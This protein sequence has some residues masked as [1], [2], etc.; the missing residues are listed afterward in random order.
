MLGPLAVESVDGAL[1]PV[2]EPKVRAVLAALLLA[3]GRMVDTDRLVDDVWSDQRP[4]DP[5]NTVQTKISQLR[6]SLDAGE[7][8]ARARV[9]HR[10]IGY[11][12]RLDSRSDLDLHRFR[13]LAA[14]AAATADPAGRAETFDAALALWRGPPLTDLAEFPFAAAAAVRLAEER[15]DALERWGRARVELGEHAAV[16]TALEPEAADHPLR[17]GLW[18]VYLRALYGCGRQADALS[19]YDALRR[20]LADGLGLDPAP[21]LVE[22]HRAMLARDPVLFAGARP[23]TPRRVL[24][25][26]ATAL[27]GRDG[28]VRSLTEALQL[29]RLVTLVGPGGVGKTRLALAL[30]VADAAAEVRLVTL[31]GTNSS[32]VI[33][34]VAEALQIGEDPGRSTA[35]R[36]AAALADRDLLVVLD[37]CERSVE[38]VAELVAHLLASTTRLR[39]LATSRRPLEVRGERTWSVPPLALPPADAGDQPA[40][41]GATGAVELFV[42]R[43]TEADPGFRLTS[44]TAG[45]IA[46]VCRRLDGI[47]LALELAATRLRALDVHELAARLDDRFR[48]LT[49]GHRDLPTR[50]RTLRAVIDSSWDPLDEPSRAVLRRL[51]VHEDGCTLAAAE[52]VCAGDPVPPGGVLDRLTDLIDRS[53]VVADTDRTGI[54][55]YRLLESV[56]EYA[57]MRLAEAG[58]TTRVRRRHAD[59]HAR[60][61]QR[62]APMVSGPEQRRWLDRLDTELPNLQRAIATL[63]EDDP[64]TATGLV[65]AL[66][67]PWFLRGRIAAARRALDRVLAAAPPRTDPARAALAWNAG[68][69]VLA[70]D[71]PDPAFADLAT[72]IRDPALRARV[73]WFLGHTLGSV[74]RLPAG[75]ALLTTALDAA[76]TAGDTW[77]E[78]AALAD[79]AGAAAARSDLTV[80]QADAERA[81][82]LFR[83]VGD[84]W[85]SLQVSFVL[86]TVAEIVGDHRGAATRHAEGLRMAEE[87]ELWP[88]VSYQLSWMGRIALLEGDLP[89][90]DNLHTRAARIA[91]EH[92]FTPGEMYALTGLALSARQTGDLDT[93]QRHLHILL[94]WHRS[95]GE[96]DTLILAELGFVAELRGDTATARKRHKAALAAAQAKADPRSV[97][98]ALEGLAGATLLDGDPAG[99]AA[100]LGEAERTRSDVGAPLPPAERGDVDRIASRARAQLGEAAYEAHRTS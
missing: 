86:G 71:P 37:E 98:L 62:A 36:I 31:G 38:R 22:L 12:L 33:D 17:E 10:S 85:G 46:A 55:R 3:S 50:Q 13:D 81:E 45:A 51:A 82:M 26:P 66:V 21:E 53:L 9:V 84:R 11:L 61:A 2:G 60:L 1:V 7:P 91:A 74:G 89:R 49:D 27:V 93:A 96:D 41:V 77:V 72:G 32:R 15:L 90:A 34:R 54:R 99:A 92:G 20:G 44:G 14:R 42:A 56:A 40:S 94:E 69:G 97:A 67:W 47:P 95:S 70:G 43:A 73:A 78:A 65:L 18:A 58:E 88:E 35:D 24:P 4:G 16:V 28:A 75:D 5:R 6:R 100:L 25:V 57:R 64:D 8:G 68:L 39:V 19:G 29:S 52:E 63:A 76:D 23:T 79:R 87:L 83:R 80:A 48:L 59:H 30:A